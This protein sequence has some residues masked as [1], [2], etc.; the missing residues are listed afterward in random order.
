MISSF[1]ECTAK[2]ALT[3]VINFFTV[4]LCCC[5]GRDTCPKSTI[6]IV[7]KLP[8]ELLY[9]L[10]YWL[11]TWVCVLASTYKPTLNPD[12]NNY[13]KL[14]QCYPLIE[15]R[16]CQLQT[17]F[18]ADLLVQSSMLFNRNTRTIREICSKAFTIKAPERQH[19]RMSFCCLCCSIWTDSTYR[20]RVSIVDFEQVNACWVYWITSNSRYVERFQSIMTKFWLVF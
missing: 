4:H 3:T 18:Q 17:F 8:R 16:G 20:S 13:V 9:C 6:K 7:V 2:N 19:W 11:W 12:L 14:C 15:I 1:P 5:R 10:L